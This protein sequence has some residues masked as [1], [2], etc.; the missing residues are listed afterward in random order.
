MICF[1]ILTRKAV[2]SGASVSHEVVLN[3]LCFTAKN[4]INEVENSLLLKCR[5]DSEIFRELD[6]IVQ[7]SW[8]TESKIYRI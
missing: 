6:E 1:E 5:D 7:E 8:E 2:Y 4:L 3:Q